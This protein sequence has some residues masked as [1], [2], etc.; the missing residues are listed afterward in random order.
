MVFPP[1]AVL[2]LL[3]IVCVVAIGLVLVTLPPTVRE[4][5]GTAGISDKAF[6]RRAV[7]LS[8]ALSNATTIKDGI[9]TIRRVA[10]D[11]KAIMLPY[12]KASDYW[13]T[14]KGPTVV[15]H[16]TSQTAPLVEYDIGLGT[17]YVTVVR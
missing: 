13:A 1:V 5:G 11:V 3:C 4:A 17:E 16:G 14:N 10:P 8:A 6:Q 7:S 15:F 2:G 9:A 12:D